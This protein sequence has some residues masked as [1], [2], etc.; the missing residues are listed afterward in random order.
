MNVRLTCLQNIFF[1]QATSART[2]PTGHACCTCRLFER[3]VVVRYVWSRSAESSK[4]IIGTMEPV[5]CA[6]AS[7]SMFTYNTRCMEILATWAELLPSAL[8]VE[9]F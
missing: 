7:I 8:H 9:D 3:D 5:M 4:A 6:L 1:A 2:D